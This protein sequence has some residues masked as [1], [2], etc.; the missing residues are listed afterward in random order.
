[1]NWVDFHRCRWLA[2]LSVAGFAAGL[3]PALRAQDTRWLQ[4]NG[5]PQVSAG[6]EVEGST[7][8]MKIGGGSST[9]DELSVTPL[10]GLHTTGSIYHPNLL[11]F[12][13]GGDLGWG[14]D[15]MTSSGSGA[16]QTRNE[17]TQL[18]RYL[19][20]FNLFSTK[21]YN[22]SFFAAQDHTYRDYGS[23]NTYLVDATR[24][25]GQM[26]WTDGAFTLNA[27]LGYRNETATGLADSS[28]ITE[29]YL[30]FLG[31]HKRK[32]GQTTLTLRANQLDNVLNGGSSLDT[33]SWAV[34]ISDSETFGHRHQISA[35][36]SL[37]YSQSE[38][39]GQ[40][41]DTLNVSENV[42]VHHRPKLDSYL[43]M[44]FNRSELLPITTASRLQGT[45]GI[46][47]QLYD[48]LASN[49]EGH[50]S[51][52]EDTA[53]AGNS[54]FDQYGLGLNENYTKRLQSWG[55]LAIGTGVIADHQEQNSPVGLQ[56]WFDEPHTL[57]SYTNP[58]YSQ[59]V[60][61]SRPRVIDSSIHVSVPGDTLVFGTDYTI[62]HSGEVTEIK[63]VAPTSPH[64]QLLLQANDNLA[65]TITYQSESLG[66]S[67]YD[68]FNFA[69]Q[70]RLDLWDQVGIYGRLN[71]LDNN[72][73]PEVLAQTLTDLVGGVDYKRKWFRT[74]AEYESYDSN[75]TQYQA[76]RF[77]QNFDFALTDAS[78]LGFDLNQTF[79]HYPENGDQAQYQFM[80]RYNVRLPMSIT[81]YLDGG[82]LYQD[83][84]GNDQVQALARTGITWTRGKLSLRAGYEF[85]GQTTHAGSFTEERTKHY[86]FTY[87]RRS[88]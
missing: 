22:A 38:F 59:P 17:S 27:D 53:A 75:F 85:N 13:L 44:N 68:T 42:L 86:F 46:Q 5:L 11:T 54:T 43:T 65:V 2:G 67:A 76:L 80:S 58:K 37:T 60:Y 83:N 23:F 10:V 29:L 40:Q 72:A 71:W 81:W 3:A 32:Y 62:I 88:F 28:E 33:T 7:E 69:A 78:S 20:E 41:M 82:A 25:G 49:L 70:I 48:S 35:G 73:P 63:L 6:V 36:T 74:G 34:G 18:L 56:T 1:M 66:S 77:F 47:H 26:N 64:V 52:E 61:L 79:Y 4:F 87:L 15:N 9:Y 57:Y 8:R 21:P 24:Y 31:I 12:D 30:N 51:H 14:W 19:A 50:G 39:S 16:N 55:R 84:P 45:A